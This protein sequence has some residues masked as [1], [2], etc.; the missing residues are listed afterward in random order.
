MSLDQPPLQIMRRRILTQRNLPPVPGQRH[1]YPLAHAPDIIIPCRERSAHP[2][3]PDQRRIRPVAPPL[4][5]ADEDPV[6]AT[7][8]RLR[9]LLPHR[10]IQ[11][12]IIDRERPEPRQLLILPAFSLRRPVE[13]LHTRAELLRIHPLRRRQVVVPQVRS[14]QA[15]GDHLRLVRIQPRPLVLFALLREQLRRVVERQ[16]Q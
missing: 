11:R 10:V 15:E 9:F 14:R 6:A 1:H 2:R 7:R 13:L 16:P 4:P 8:I 3:V 12:H 5:V